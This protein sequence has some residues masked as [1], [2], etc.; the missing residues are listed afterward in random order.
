MERV[1]ISFQDLWQEPKLSGRIDPAYPVL[2][3][4]TN[5]IYEVHEREKKTKKQT[6]KNKQK[7][8]LRCDCLY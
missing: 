8:A 4:V 2:G 3:L 7:T 1:Y 6:K 5:F